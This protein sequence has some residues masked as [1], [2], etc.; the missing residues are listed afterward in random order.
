MV[1]PQVPQ[2]S[3]RTILE[4]ELETLDF[5]ISRHPLSLYVRAAFETAAMSEA[6]TSRSMSASG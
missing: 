4:H 5:L 2:Y 3:A 1:P 6:R